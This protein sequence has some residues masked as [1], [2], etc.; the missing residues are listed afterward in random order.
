MAQFAAGVDDALRRKV[1]AWTNPDV[2]RQLPGLMH[3]AELRDVAVTPHVDVT[4]EVPDVEAWRREFNA[5]QVTRA[6][7][8]RHGRC[9]ADDVHQLLAQYEAAA[10]SGGYVECAVHFAV[11]GT[12]AL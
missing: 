10:R 7:T 11:L 1:S 2:G 12:K 5:G 4:T 6:A 9:T 8:V 3:R